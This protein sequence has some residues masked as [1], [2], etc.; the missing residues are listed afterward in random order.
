MNSGD[1]HKLHAT[2]VSE[3]TLIGFDQVEQYLSF[4]LTGVCAPVQA[5]ALERVPAV[6]AD[7]P[8]TDAHRL[9]SS[10]ASSVNGLEN[11]VQVQLSTW[12]ERLDHEYSIVLYFAD[13]EQGNYIE[14][15]RQNEQWLTDTFNFSKLGGG[16]RF[17]AGDR[18]FKFLGKVRRRM[19]QIPFSP[20][21]P[22]QAGSHP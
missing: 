20:S 14:V 4:A 7:A 18:A 19:I 5:F 8:P 12:H 16:I 17:W 9:T 22:C 11:I 1:L 3:C 10:V 21:S 6:V 13:T 15:V 2:S